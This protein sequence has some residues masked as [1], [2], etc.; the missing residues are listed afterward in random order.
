MTR[1]ALILLGVLVA[2]AGVVFTLQGVG[3]LKGSSMTSTTEWTVL[4]PIIALIGAGVAAISVR[5]R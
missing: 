1:V 5:R 2:V 3:L 4:G